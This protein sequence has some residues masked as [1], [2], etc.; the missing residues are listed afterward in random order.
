M[1]TVQAENAELGDGKSQLRVRT[2]GAAFKVRMNVQF[3]IS[4]LERMSGAQVQLNACVVGMKPVTF[5][6]MEGSLVHVVMPMS[7]R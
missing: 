7:V 6:P 5:R 3:A 4:A 1:L 2:A